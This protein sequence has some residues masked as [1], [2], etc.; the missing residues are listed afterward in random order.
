MRHYSRHNTTVMQ[1][2]G[3]DGIYGNEDDIF[4]TKQF[5]NFG[6]TVSTQSQVSGE[7]ASVN[8][9]AYTAGASDSANSNIR[10]LNRVNASASFGE[11][12]VNPLRNGSFEY[13]GGWTEYMEHASGGVVYTP[14]ESYTG[15]RSV[16]ID[17]A[18][19]DTAARD[20]AEDPFTIAGFSQ[21][22]DVSNFA[23]TPEDA[24]DYADN[25]PYVASAYVKAGSAAIF[26]SETASAVLL[27]VTVNGEMIA[28]IAF[29]FLLAQEAEDGWVRVMVPFTVPDANADVRVGG[30]IVNTTGTAYFDGIQVEKG[31]TVG[32]YNL[33][34]NA[35]F[36]RAGLENWSTQDF[37]SGDALTVADKH[38]GGKAFQING[39]W[40]KVK[41]LWQ[42]VPVNGSEKDVYALGGWA[43][44]DAVNRTYSDSVMKRF[45]L[46]ALV[47]YADGGSA[48]KSEIWYNPSVADWQYASGAFDLS[49]G[50]PNTERIPIGIRVYVAYHNQGNTAYFDD[51]SLVK[52]TKTAYNYDSEGNLTAAAAGEQEASAQYPA[53]ETKPASSTDPNGNTTHYE[54]DNQD[55]LTK[56][57]SA[58]GVEQNVTYNADGQVASSAVQYGS[59]AKLLTEAVY[60]NDGVFQI[61]SKDAHGRAMNYEYNSSNGNLESATD[62]GGGTVEYTYDANGQRLTGANAEGMTSAYGYENG[63]LDTITH[64]GFHYGFAYDSF[65]NNTETT[66]G[67]RTLQTNEYGENNGVLKQS[68]L[69]NNGEQNYTYDT[70]GRVML[71]S[72]LKGPAPGAGI[73]EQILHM[74]NR[75]LN[76]V[77]HM[78]DEQGR[79]IMAFGTSNYFTYA[80][81]DMG[82][83][84]RSHNNGAVQ[85]YEYDNNNNLKKETLTTDGESLNTEGRTLNTGHVYGAADFPE[86]TLLPNQTAKSYG[87]DTLGRLTGTSIPGTTP[88]QAAYTYKASSRGSGFTTTQLD[89]ETLNSGSYQYEYDNVGNI[90]KIKKKNT[91]GV[92]AE[93]I[94][95]TYDSLYRLVRENNLDLNKTIVYTYDNGNNITSKQVYDYTTGTPSGTPQTFAYTYND[96]EWNDLLTGCNGQTFTHDE[97]GNPLSYRDG[98]SM[99]WIGRELET[100]Q[101]S[102]LEI[103]Y[104]YSYEGLRQT[105]TVN[106]ADTLYRYIDGRLAYEK[107]ENPDGTTAQELYYIYDTMG[108]LSQILHVNGSGNETYY[109]VQTNSRGD[110]TGLYHAATG[111]AAATYTYDTWGNVLAVTDAG[112]N[113]IADPGHIGNL[114]PVRYR[115]YYYDSETGLY[116]LKSRYYDPQVGRFINADT[117]L[118]SVGEADNHN[119]FAYCLN[120]PVMYCDPTGHAVDALNKPFADAFRIACLTSTV[121]VC[122]FS[123]PN[124][125]VTLN[126]TLVSPFAEGMNDMAWIEP[127]VKVLEVPGANT[128]SPIFTVPAPP[129]IE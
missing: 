85:S 101:K 117:L 118:G 48:W 47:L 46:Q 124:I 103:E 83:L 62:A 60:S 73:M 36:E 69:G 86:M 59:G 93:H 7:L 15:K 67:S 129:K 50:D 24:E 57:T 21:Q 41:E 51:I 64:N 31:M 74:I 55:R 91:A 95:Y 114:N 123:W 110:V 11:G 87:Y 14:E 81:D 9:T 17:A 66:I 44:A 30:A 19:A 28:D 88:L 10:Q 25:H 128:L 105:K 115:G 111:A 16:R 6:R 29:N 42:D 75:I 43:K 109:N 80:Y 27:F 121:R 99:T 65:G 104:S 13:A 84:T 45:R 108:S 3:I 26:D 116:Y 54:Y 77:S 122:V 98:M 94:G 70:K 34:E 37:M 1:T 90:T 38:S 96:S 63:M 39:A 61:A 79:R 112:G 127:F 12:V 20:L 76:T 68:T 53:G 82:R 8:N 89:T 71:S 126:C 52:T 18:S 2:A 106:E 119:V 78:Y 49:D 102:G 125:S 4:T 32:K 72:R 58:R 107:R 22:L 100:L 113:V 97:I 120:N 40:K 35:G 92:Y 5:D 56:T 33:I 23:Y